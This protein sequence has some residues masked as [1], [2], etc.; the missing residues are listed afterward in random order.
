MM[1]TILLWLRRDLRL[2]DHPAL[3]AAL[4][5][6]LPILPVYIHAPAEEAPWSPGAAS[7]W[8]LHHSLQ[9]LAQDLSACGSRLL[10]RQG[11]SLTQLRALIQTCQV[12]IIYWS[13]VYEPA[14]IERDRRIKAALRADGLEVHSF[15][16]NLLHEPWTVQTGSGGPY[17]VFTPYWNTCRQR[18]CDVPLPAPTQLPAPDSWP[19]GLNLQDLALLP[20]IPWDS[21]LA[22]AWQVGEGA[23][24]MRLRHFCAKIHAHYAVQRDFPALDGVSRLSPHLHFGE[25][26][27]RQIFHA[28]EPGAFTRQLFWR[29]FAY[30]LLF[31][32]PA[33]AQ[34]PWNPRYQNFSWREAP[35]LLRAWQNGTTGWPLIDAGM[36][37]LW[38][39]GWMHNRVRM[40]CASFLSKNCLLPWLAGAKWFWDTLV[41]ADLANNTLGWQWV[42]GCGADA[43]PYTRVFNPL[44]QAQRFDPQGDYVR[45]W[46]PALGKVPDKFIHHPHQAGLRLD[47]P[48]PVLDLALSRQDFLSAA[49]F[50]NARSKQ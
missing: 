37:E 44:R 10:L 31:H 18:P 47:Y 3:Q 17:K 4:H 35:A 46:L 41:D 20:K 15:P 36:Q 6:G 45:R 32:F 23:A 38:Q 7:R 9:A 24:H 5:T 22:R 21:G 11:D 19:S 16:G 49:A 1:P 25:I 12:K 2:S 28:L 34:A 50:F 26:T 48:L 27:P 33:S 13:R 14:L 29:E 8:W 30:H 42:A 39:S 40:I 43:A